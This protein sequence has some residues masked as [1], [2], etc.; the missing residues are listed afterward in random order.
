MHGV[1][2]VTGKGAEIRA[3]LTSDVRCLKWIESLKYLNPGQPLHVYQLRIPYPRGIPI[4]S[5][6]GPVS[7][8]FGV[9]LWALCTSL[10]TAHRHPIP[11]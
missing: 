11:G 2:L 9:A 1:S 6:Q 10:K 5:W 8:R 3:L 4:P 7:A